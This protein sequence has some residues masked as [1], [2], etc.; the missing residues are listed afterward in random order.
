MK[1]YRIRHIQK[2]THTHSQM[3]YKHMKKKKTKRNGEHC[4]KRK[5]FVFEIKSRF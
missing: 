1:S 5:N 3:L 2:K 4:I